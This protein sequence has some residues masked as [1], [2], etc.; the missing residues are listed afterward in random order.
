M[1][2]IWVDKFITPREQEKLKSMPLA[3]RKLMVAAKGT[4]NLLA[5]FAKIS[6]AAPNNL[7]KKSKKSRFL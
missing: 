4:Q 5:L 6:P 7:R 3:R 2:G 1:D